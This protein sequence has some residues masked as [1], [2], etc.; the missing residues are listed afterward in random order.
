MIVGV[1]GK[2]VRFIIFNGTQV[3]MSGGLDCC[4]LVFGATLIPGRRHDI[5]LSC[6]STKGGAVAFIIELLVILAE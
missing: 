3:S 4:I 2:W 5:P 6:S 1:G